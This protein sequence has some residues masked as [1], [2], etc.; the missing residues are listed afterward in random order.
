MLGAPAE[1]G[2]V[3]RIR[4]IGMYAYEIGC[5]REGASD[6]ALKSLRKYLRI[7]LG[8]AIMSTLK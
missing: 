7:G 3:F 4:F 1:C 5:K 8:C 6:K 2:C